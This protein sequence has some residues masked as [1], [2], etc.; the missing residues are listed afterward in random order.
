MR[1]G[2]VAFLIAI[3]CLSA[4]RPADACKTPPPCAAPTTFAS[5]AEATTNL[6]ATDPAIA[7]KAAY[8]LARSTTAASVKTL[9]RTLLGDSFVASI[10]KAPDGRRCSMPAILRALAENPLGRA[11]FVTLIQSKT[12]AEVT[13]KY[14]GSERADQLLRASGAIR[15]PP[16]EVVAYWKRH[17]NPD[18]GW[19]NVTVMAL[20][21]N[22][23]DQASAMFESLLRNAKHDVETR[24][25][26]LHGNFIAHRHEVRML[27]IALRLLTS[28]PKLPAPLTTALGEVVFDYRQ[29]WYGTCPG[30]VAPA[31]DKYTPEA[32]KLVRLI[33]VKV[34]ANGPDK[35]LAEAI[36]KT[37]SVL[38]NGPTKR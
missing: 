23:S 38:D 24:A 5:D 28:R 37:I 32:R 9:G 19:V 34:R 1:L 14:D 31:L 10:L 3:L 18:D 16:P 13:T 20:A 6:A 17:A 8:T 4:T 26:W 29:D 22:G 25:S 15:P 2:H 36:T 7:A 30:P 21:D 12:W 33:A 35:Q 11:S 27:G